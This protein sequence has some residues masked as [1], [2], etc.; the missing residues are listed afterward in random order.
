ME[1]ERNIVFDNIIK[2]VQKDKSILNLLDYDQLDQ[3]L[4]YLL[5]YNEFLQKKGKN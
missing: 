3:F 5:E 1:F 2:K 4:N